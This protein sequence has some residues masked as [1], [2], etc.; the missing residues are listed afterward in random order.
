[1]WA[2]EMFPDLEK[3]MS[4][5]QGILRQR[6]VTAMGKMLLETNDLLGQVPFVWEDYV[7]CH[8]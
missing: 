3:N 1:M 5:A 2:K 7:R 8:K 4:M 6:R